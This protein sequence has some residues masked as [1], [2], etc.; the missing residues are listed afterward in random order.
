MFFIELSNY[1]LLRTLTLSSRVK[2][3]RRSYLLLLLRL[4]VVCLFS[5]AVGPRWR[6][7]SEL[8]TRCRLAREAS[9][10]GT[11]CVVLSKH[12]KVEVCIDDVKAKHASEEKE[13]K[14]ENGPRGL[15]RS[16]TVLDDA[17][18]V[19]AVGERRRGDQGGRPATDRVI[20]TRTR[21]ATGAVEQYDLE[22]RAPE[23]HA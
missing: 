17:D 11:L 13:A 19:L 10:L 2:H 12:A 21:G 20:Q 14:E 15:P 1:N 22:P 6:V 16:K 18:T 9:P 7:G 3:P 8:T 5:V 4:V 23:S